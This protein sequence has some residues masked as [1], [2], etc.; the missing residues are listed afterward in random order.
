M[1]RILAIALILSIFPWRVSAQTPIGFSSWSLTD[2][3][4]KT[5]FGG[6]PQ[7]YPTSGGWDVIDNTFLISGDTLAYN[8]TDLVKTGVD[9]GG[10]TTARVDWSGTTVEITQEPWGLQWLNIATKARTDVTGAPTWNIP[11]VDSNIV[12]WTGVW[13][14]V[15]YEVHKVNGGVQHRVSFRPAF[16]DSAVTLYDQRSD[17]LDIALGF[18]IKYD[19]SASINNHDSAIGT[20]S[21]RRLKS[22]GEGRFQRF[23]DLTAQRIFYPGS[24]TLVPI[25]V[26]Q[27][28]VK[29]GGNIYCV[30]YV[31]M[32]TLKALH[33][34]NPGATIWHNSEIEIGGIDNIED[35]EMRLTT[36]DNNFGESI[37]MRCRGDDADPPKSAGLLR[38]AALADFLGPDPDVDS[39]I[40]NI[41][42]QNNYVSGTVGIFQVNQNWVEGTANGA[43]QS[44][45]ASYND[46][47][48]PDSAWEVAPCD[49]AHDSEAGADRKATAMDYMSVTGTGWCAFYFDPDTVTAWAIGTI[50]NNGVML[51]DSS[52][53]YRIFRTSE[54][55]SD[56]E[57]YVDVY[58]TGGWAS[59]DNFIGLPEEPADGNAS[60]SPD[61]TYIYNDPADHDGRIV[62]F[63]YFPFTDADNG[64]RVAI[65]SK[66][67]DVYTSI[68]AS[69]TIYWTDVEELKSC[70]FYDG[71]WPDSVPIDSGQYV[72]FYAG[73][74]ARAEASFPAV[75][76]GYFS[77][78]GDS[79]D[80]GS[81]ITDASSFADDIEIRWRIDT[82]GY[83]D[84]EPPEGVGFMM[85]IG[86]WP[87][88]P[89]FPRSGPLYSERV[90]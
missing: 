49:S 33:E 50:P 64:F 48:N 18:I 53:G 38:I 7:N 1:K 34:A 44:G 3:T 82:V 8:K 39:T 85:M 89:T 25:P 32:S 66:S 17:S 65:Y 24:D 14:G 20:C 73:N 40:G 80:V 42:V 67:G 70:W 12:K 21:W 4:F 37:N 29:T 56:L 31:M 69:D 57:P 22:M 74:V 83:G 52:A 61:R 5:R 10:K 60:T 51:R 43:V 2:T 90:R 59:W 58:Y 86:Y 47:I 45:S 79:T 46:Y 27:R 36:P 62:G 30:E 9:L 87:T 78:S 55:G 13:P 35:T 26:M 88:E 75:T 68:W 28:W 41:N 54:Y 77:E 81:T 72:G 23:F 76:G 16:L 71:C 6:P 84:V 63:E 15:N 11:S 19:L